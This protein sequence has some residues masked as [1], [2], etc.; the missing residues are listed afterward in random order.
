MRGCRAPHC[1]PEPSNAA[2]GRWHAQAASTV[3]AC[4]SRQVLSCSGGVVASDGLKASLVC[5]S[6][7]ASR[8]LQKAGSDLAVHVGSCTCQLGPGLLQA[9]AH[10][11]QRAPG[12]QPQLQRSH[13]RSHQL[14]WQDREGCV[15]CHA[16]AVCRSCL[17][18]PACVS[19][20]TLC[21]AAS[22]GNAQ[23]AVLSGALRGSWPCPPAQAAQVSNEPQPAA[24]NELEQ[25]TSTAPAWRRALIHGAAP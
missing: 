16:G 11:W 14:S 8:R 9:Q 6:Q 20:L 25:R 12:Q 13:L 21:S 2:H 23:Q 18:L 1:W 10:L 19:G 17:R 5:G 4:S 7:S 3:Q 24:D 22:A 15:L